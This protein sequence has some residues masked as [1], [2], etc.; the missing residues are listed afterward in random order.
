MITKL[1][2]FVALTAWL[3]ASTWGF[4]QGPTPRKV[5]TN[6]QSFNVPLRVEDSDRAVLKELRFYVKPPNGNW[7]LQERG[8]PQATRFSYQAATDG[9]YWFAFSTV[10]SAG[11]E[12]PISPEHELPRL[13]VVVDTKAPEVGAAPLTV[14]SGQTYIQCT[15]RDANP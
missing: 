10:D 4:A 13:I 8:T 14:A 2:R 6:R 11:R 15:I 7:V 3:A 1:S 5:F 9:E 12:S